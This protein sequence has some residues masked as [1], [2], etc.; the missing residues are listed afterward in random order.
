MNTQ[1]AEKTNKIVY[2]SKSQNYSI[3]PGSPIAYWVSN[4]FR[5]N[6]TRG[7]RFDSF[8]EPKS[9]VM[10]G[11]DGKFVKFWH[12]V[13]TN[14]I[15]FG[16]H[17]SQEMIASQKK[18]FPVT[19]GGTYRKWYGNLEEI[20]NLE[21]DGYAIRNN[22]KNYRLRDRK[23]YL[24][25]GLTWT[26]ITT[27]RLS[28]RLAEQGILFGNGGPTTFVQKNPMYLLALLNCT[29]ANSVIQVLNPTMNI[30]INDI[31]AI[32]VIFDD[33]KS[34]EELSKKCIELSKEDWNSAETSW[35]FKKHPL[36]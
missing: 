24:Q 5:T 27:N 10:T 25:Q 1:T 36:L 33:V 7:E 18:W 28:V 6:F 13:M 9:G 2:L 35:D 34:V 3:I 31:C 11:D 16:L 17:N 19:R 14:K 26:M 30:V 8:G 20:V 4:E 15:G 23:Y 32:P 21:N 12:E 29:V 22:G